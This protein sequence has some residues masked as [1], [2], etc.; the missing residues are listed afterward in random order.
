MP[1]QQMLLGAGGAAVATTPYVDDVFSTYLYK[2]TGSTINIVNG[3][4]NSGEGGMVWLKNRGSTDDHMLSDTV[5]GYNKKLI[6]N[7]SAGES[8]SSGLSSFNNNGF[9]INGSSWGPANSSG[10]TYAT[11][12]FRKS[13]G[14]FDIVTYTG[15]GSNRTIAHSLGSVPGCIMIKRTESIFFI[16][17]SSIRPR[18]IH[19]SISYYMKK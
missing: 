8:T 16:R 12:N 18:Y 14:F 15:N 10:D 11:F 5:R 3:I 9:T 2:G 1:I 17:Y 13:P 19:Y 6:S 7:S 4:D